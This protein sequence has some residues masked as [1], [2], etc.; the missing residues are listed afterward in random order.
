MPP[1]ESLIYRLC[2]IMMVYGY[3]Y[4]AV[5]NEMFG[6]GI[7]SAISFSIKVEREGEIRSQSKFV[8]ITMGGRW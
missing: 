6:D 5:I 4:K 2:E 3:A 8:V 7:M 1:T